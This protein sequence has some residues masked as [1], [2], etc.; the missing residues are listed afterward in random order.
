MFALRNAANDELT[1]FGT[2]QNNEMHRVTVVADYATGIANA[3][4]DGVL[5]FGSY[6]LR[7]GIDNA[8]T[9]NELFMYMNGES[10]GQGN[11]VAVDNLVGYHYAN[12]PV[13]EPASLIIWS[14]LGLTMGGASW[15]RRRKRAK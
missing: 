13:P 2:Y 12:A 11:S 9:Y 7:G 4:L 6:P 10:G 5:G 1:T 3:Y 14:L 8:S 15:W